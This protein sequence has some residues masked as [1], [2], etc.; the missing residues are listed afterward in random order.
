MTKWKNL[1][2]MPVCG[3]ALAVSGCAVDGGSMMQPVSVPAVAKTMSGNVH[4]GQQ[5]IAGAAIQLYAVGITGLKSA[6]TPLLRS[7]VTTGQDGS[8]TITG[9]WDCTSNTATYGTNPLLY[10][11]ASGGNPG[12]AQATNNTAAIMM[13]ALGPCDSVGASTFISLDE[14]TTVGAAFALAP[15]MSDAAHVGAMGANAVGLTNAFAIANVLVNTT[16]GLAPGSGLPA[17]V[18]VPV[19]EL[20]SVADMLAPCVNSTGVD[21][22]CTPL[23]A[24]VTTGSTPPSDIVAA[25]LN[26]VANPTANGQPSSLLNLVSGT[27]PF[28]PTLATPPNDWT[29][30]LNFKGGGLNAPAALALD[31]SGNAWVANSGGN[32]VTELSVTGALLTGVNGYTGNSNIFGAQGIA[33]DRAGSVW[34]ADTLLSSVIKLTVSGGAVQGNTSYANSSISGPIALAIDSQ[35]DVWVSNFAGASITELSSS[36]A[37]MGSGALSANGSL[38]APMGIAIDPLGNVWV[39]DSAAWDMVEFNNNQVLLSGAGYKDGAMVSPQDVAL[40]SN[41]HAWIADQG[42]SSVSLLGT[43]GNSLLTTPLMGGGLSM[44]VA[45]AID[46]NGTVWIVNNVTAGSVSELRFGQSA[47]I[48]PAAGLGAMNAPDAIAVDASG[49]VWT[50]NAGDNSVSEIIGIAAPAVMPLAANAGP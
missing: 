10:I 38:Q 17:N 1:A 18:T 37:V 19:A 35:N 28:Q 21:G 31:A 41:E 23:F 44:P 49:N 50:A 5:P 29:V 46:G 12:L 13:A 42:S 9:D 24:A 34:V 25:A 26:I 39:A 48:S 3:L 36:G 47:P 7:A 43:F 40:D 16:T 30:A 15:F 22:S 33:I 4:G 6:S 27:A 45:A 14:V 2:M 32:S 20:N 8:F 11:T